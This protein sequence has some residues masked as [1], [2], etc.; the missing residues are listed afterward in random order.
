MMSGK[1]LK[2]NAMLSGLKTMMS[3]LFPLITFPYATR[4]LQVENLGKVNFSSSII[5]YFMLLAALGISTYAIREGSRKRNDRKELNEFANQVFTI[6]IISTVISYLAL[7]FVIL[8][9]PTLQ[10]YKMLLIIQSTTII[11]TTVGVD[12]LF[13]IYEDYLYI[14]IRS[15]V[16]QL[17]S[18]L[19][20][21]ILVR[22]TNDY[23]IYAMVTVISSVGSNVLNY[24]H[25]KKYFKIKLTKNL[26]LKKH[27][28]PI[29]IIF[30]ISIASTIYVNSDLT[31]VGIMIGDHAVGIYS[32]SSKVY[33]VVKT[34][35]S[36][37]IIVSLP[38]LSFYIANNKEENYKSTVTKIFNSI[39]LI[40]LPTVV[41]INILS[42]QIIMIISGNSYME[43][44]ISLRILS[45]AL[46]FSIFAS[47]ATAAILLPMKKEKYILIATIVGAVVNVLLNLLLIPLFQQNGAAITTAVA[48]F[49]VML[50]SLYHARKYIKLNNVVKNVATSIAG[51]IA[52]IFVSFVLKMLITNT[53][54]YTVVI[55]ICSISIYLL[56]LLLLKNELALEL[57]N[58]IKKKLRI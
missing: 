27:L 47:F 48:E 15:L 16:F 54:V 56:V 3:V 11:F 57:I 38:R 30:S 10:N 25:S 28:K 1:S 18:M 13:S 31:M 7:F 43:A 8:L 23:Y 40:I 33:S 2:I 35:L 5:S 45:I 12:W 22:D 44:N 17:V 36:A 32:V 6:N 50:I 52:I 51:C 46:L 37:V 29:F 19:L 39:L 42:N 9:V 4:I 41:G 49:L 21:F 55:I 14:T 20:L 53:M 58:G 26:N 24:V 34:V